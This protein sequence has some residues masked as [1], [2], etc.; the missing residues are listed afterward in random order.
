MIKKINVCLMSLT[1]C[2]V[3]RAQDI[4]AERPTLISE[5]QSVSQLSVMPSDRVR[6]TEMQ[7]RALVDRGKQHERE[8]KAWQEI[9]QRQFKLKFNQLAAAVESFAKQYNENK[10]TIWPQREADKLRKAM[11]QLQSFEKSLRDDPRAASAPRE[12]DS[13][14]ASPR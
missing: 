9:Q 3:L 4:A 10:G 11:R 5:A 12:C 8:V 2:V 7:E 6:T 1:F 14:V 13:T